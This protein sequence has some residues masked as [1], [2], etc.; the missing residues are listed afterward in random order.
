[1]SAQQCNSKHDCLKQPQLP[2][3]RNDGLNTR[4]CETCESKDGV[5]R[6]SKLCPDFSTDNATA[7]NEALHSLAVHACQTFANR[8]T[9]MNTKHTEK[10]ETQSCQLT[11]C[12]AD[13]L[14]RTFSHLMHCSRDLSDCIIQV[15]FL[16][17]MCVN[18][19]QHSAQRDNPLYP[20]A[21]LSLATIA[22]I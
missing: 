18:T 19:A 5:D 11:H 1:M 10:T 22:P 20:A 8:M 13:R 12:S 15:P 21:F 4:Y 16:I 7:N 2:Q 9:Q 17:S 14:I 3:R 6:L